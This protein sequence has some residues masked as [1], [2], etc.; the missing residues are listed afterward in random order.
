MKAK[1]F[2]ISVLFI[3]FVLPFIG[4]KNCSG[5]DE[6]SMQ[7]ESCVIESPVLKNYAEFYYDLVLLTAF[8]GFPGIIYI[9]GVAII[10]WGGQK[11]IIKY[12]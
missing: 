2:G 1:I 4:M 9:S 3:A 11:V 7:V 5:Y 8:T 12:F 10:I 6:G